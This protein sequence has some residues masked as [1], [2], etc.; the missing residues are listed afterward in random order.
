MSPELVY[1]HILSLSKNENMIKKNQTKQPKKKEKSCPRRE[2]NPG[3]FASEVNT[4][5]IAHESL[6]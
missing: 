3:P 1:R 6:C 4:V 2:S 5:F